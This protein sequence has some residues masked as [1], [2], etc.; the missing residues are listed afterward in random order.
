MITV[1]CFVIIIIIIMGY[2]YS[3]YYYYYYLHL[4]TNTN[5]LVLLQSLLQSLMFLWNGGIKTITF[6]SSSV[7]GFCIKVGQSRQSVLHSSAQSTF[8]PG[9]IL[10]TY[11]TYNISVYRIPVIRGRSV[12]TETRL[13]DGWW[14]DRGS[15]PS[16]EYKCSCSAQAPE[17]LWGSPSLL[18]IEYWGPFLSE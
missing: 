7:F 10:T 3:Y 18:F 14:R 12:G 9:F 17:Q 13:R 15:T 6:W 1:S 11:R 16:G 4:F 8:Y 5:V 2:D